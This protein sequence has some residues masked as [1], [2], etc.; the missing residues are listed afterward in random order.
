MDASAGTGGTYLTV[1]GSSPLAGT[2]PVS[3]QNS[4]CGGTGVFSITNTCT[5]GDVTTTELTF[6][7]PLGSV[8]VTTM[9]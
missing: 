5:A 6:A 2:Y 9:E 3:D 8:M 7:N 4:T 1:T